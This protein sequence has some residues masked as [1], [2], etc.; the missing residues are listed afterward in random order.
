M[1]RRYRLQH[2]LQS[3][4]IYIL[5]AR[6]PGDIVYSIPYSPYTSIYSQQD[7]PAISSTAY[8]TVH[9]HLYTHSKTTRRYRLQRTLQSI[10]IYI[11][12][13]RRP[14]DIVY[15]VPYSPYTSIYSQQDDPA[16]SSTAYPTVHIYIYTHSKTTRRYRL[17][18]TLQSIYIYIY[19]QQ[20]DPAIS[21]TAYPTVQAWS[22]GSFTKMAI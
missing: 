20:D 22:S 1:T 18:H 11:L 19:S 5:T 2:T 4:Y 8:P 15:S 21:S 14:G 16:I 7:D 17:Q 12:T 9:I 3:I 6:R 13:A 10:Y